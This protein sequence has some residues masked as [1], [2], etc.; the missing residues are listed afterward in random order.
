MIADGPYQCME[1]LRY[2]NVLLM[3]KGKGRKFGEHEFFYNSAVMYKAS[4]TL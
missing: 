2:G 1:K 4:F 3:R